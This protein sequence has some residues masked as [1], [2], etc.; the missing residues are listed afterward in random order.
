M[1]IDTFGLNYPYLQPGKLSIDGIH[2]ILEE[3]RKKGNLG[4]R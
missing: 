2:T 3:L 1:D 4:L